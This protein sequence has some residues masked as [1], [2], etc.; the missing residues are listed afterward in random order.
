MIMLHSLESINYLKVDSENCVLFDFAGDD[1]EISIQQQ[2][3]KVNKEGLGD[4]TK[5]D[6]IFKIRIFEITL[7]ELLL[8]QSIQYSATL[9][10]ILALVKD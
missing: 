9:T 4:Q 3:R 10:D 1:K 5:F 8:L 7:R 2:Y 6:T